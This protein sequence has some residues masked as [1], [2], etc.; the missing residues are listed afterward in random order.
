MEI[1]RGEFGGA[2]WRRNRGEM[3]LG[4]LGGGFLCDFSS[5]VSASVGHW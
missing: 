4:R 3:A 1:V 2:F 5:G